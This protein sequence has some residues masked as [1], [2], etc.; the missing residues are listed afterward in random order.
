M[1]KQGPPRYNCCASSY[2]SPTERMAA[3][4][5][6]RNTKPCNGNHLRDNARRGSRRECAIVDG[7][8]KTDD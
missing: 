7:K 5:P 2:N 1:S 3:G 8:M 6:L 4:R